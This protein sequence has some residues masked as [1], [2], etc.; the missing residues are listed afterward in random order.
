MSYFTTQELYKVLLFLRS[1]VWAPELYPGPLSSGWPVLPG[2]EGVTE[3]VGCRFAGSQGAQPWGLVWG[4]PHR[5]LSIPRT[6]KSGP[7]YQS[8]PWESVSELG[9]LVYLGHNNKKVLL[10]ID[11]QYTHYHTIYRSYTGAVLS[12]L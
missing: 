1:F 11:S 9:S 5:G 10:L 7:G 6:E 8:L 2:S 3:G 12:L 4:S